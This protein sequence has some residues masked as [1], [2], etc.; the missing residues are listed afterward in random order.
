MRKS[1]FNSQ[2]MAIYV[3]AGRLVKT[4]RGL[5]VHD[6]EALIATSSMLVNKHQRLA[7]AGQQLGFW[8]IEVPFLVLTYFVVAFLHSC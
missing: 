7:R 5:Q 6:V 2:V 3:S 8:L 4:K 1:I